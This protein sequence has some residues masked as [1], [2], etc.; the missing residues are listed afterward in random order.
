M[1]FPDAFL[2]EIRARLTVSDVVG[3]RVKLKRQGRE[4]LGLSP[5]KQ[6]KTP[7][8]TV[9]DQKGF[10]HCFSSGE[11]GDIFTF[12]MKTEGLSFPEAVERLAQEAGLEVP[13]PTARDEARARGRERLQ[14]AMETACRFYEAALK[15]VTGAHARDYLR[16]RGVGPETCAAFRLG[17][18]GRD[19]HGLK[20]HLAG[21]GFTQEE[22]VEAGLLI[23]GEDIPVSYDRFRER[24][25]FPIRDHRGGVIAFG[26]RALSADAKAKYVNSPETPLF[27]K[28]RVLFNIAGARQA[29]YERGTVIAVEGYMDV[30]A[31]A[32]AGFQNAV[33][34]LGTALT[35]E[36]IKLLWRMAP[37]PV[38]CFDGDAAGRRAAYRALDTALPLLAPG[39]SLG[40]A[41]LPAGQDPDDVIREDGVEAFQALL[42]KARPLA[43]VL[44]T[45]ETEAGVWDTP[46]RRAALEAR[47][48]ALVSEISDPKVRQHYAQELQARLA[49]FWAP[50]GAPERGAG[51]ARSRGRGTPWRGR[52]GTG[53]DRGPFDRS[54]A[55]VGAGASE[56]L[57]QSDLVRGAAAQPNTREALL[58]ATLLN[59]PWLLDAYAEEIAAVRLHGA[60]ERLRDAIMSVYAAQNP[61]DSEALRTQL[62]NRGLGAIVCR[63]EHAITHKSD[64][65]VQATASRQD[66][67]MGWRQILA[68]H[69][70]SLELERELKAAER[71]FRDEGTEE[72]FARLRDVRLQLLNAEGTEASLEAEPVG[73]EPAAGAGG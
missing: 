9:N 15:D 3:R 29:A 26:G 66:V 6:E 35:S 50:L 49:R 16:E 46:E 60:P 47:V 54:Q 68:L 44:W 39:F 63:V 7:S 52:T 70:R 11:H 64:L 72:A 13:K 5:F 61:L 58:L 71:A 67:E 17:Y 37:E 32:Q 19:R 69:R 1:R 22:M 43:D 38:L 27:H 41:F 36:Q 21:E 4:F 8:F 53:R 33:A 56:S 25:I 45:R 73:L 14:A 65:F 2:D 48:E 62:S 10:Y 18:G 28:S 59:H 40:F 55:H 23:A 12:L 42:A 31:L 24:L 20:Q 34:P 30:I 57:R 51:P